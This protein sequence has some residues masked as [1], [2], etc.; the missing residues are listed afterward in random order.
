[1]GTFRDEAEEALGK[2][3]NIV[4]EDIA[5]K[6]GPLVAIEAFKSFMEGNFE[7]TFVFK[8]RLIAIT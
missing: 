3:N 4:V 8:F 5:S 1:M 6:D 7:V 2:G